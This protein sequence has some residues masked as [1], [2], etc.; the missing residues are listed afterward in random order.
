MG[1]GYHSRSPEELK[2]YL[3]SLNL[4]SK[5]KP[6]M[7][8]VIVA[9]IIGIVF[10]LFVIFQDQSLTS[11]FKPSNK[12]QVAESEAYFTKSNESSPDSINY[13]L[14]VKNSAT[15]ENTFPKKEMPHRKS[16]LTDKNLIWPKGTRES[17]TVTPKGRSGIVLDVFWGIDAEP[18]FF[19][20]NLP[21]GCA[22]AAGKTED[23][24]RPQPV[25]KRQK[26]TTFR[27]LKIISNTPE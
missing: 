18:L 12:I 1:S 8:Y 21:S 24:G 7:Q 4:K 9:N 3:E 11:S 20:S 10:V 23:L 22:V 15:V 2:R 19:G 26:P 27:Y 14:F 25:K 17:S 6:L 5:K 13:F 16:V